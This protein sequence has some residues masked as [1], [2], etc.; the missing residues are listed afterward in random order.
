M[1]GLL[2]R[3]TIVPNYESTEGGL[4][5]RVKAIHKDTIKVSTPSIVE[6]KEVFIFDDVWTSGATLRACQ[7]V[8]TTAGAESVKLFVV[9]KTVYYN[10]KTLF[11]VN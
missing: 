1:V 4:E 6:G 2:V 9:G 11:C 8:V 10:L 7:E 5:V 3:T